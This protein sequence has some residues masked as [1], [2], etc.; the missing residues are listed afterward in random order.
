MELMP[1]KPLQGIPLSHKTM[2]VKILCVLCLAGLT[3]ACQT[4]PAVDD[5]HLSLG[6]KS[7]RFLFAGKITTLAFSQGGRVLIA[8]GCEI[9]DDGDDKQ[10]DCP[11]SLVQK[12]N[13]DGTN[14]EKTLRYLQRT[15]ALAVSPD[16]S[17]L[18]AGDSEGRLSLL[19][20]AAKTKLKALHQKREI[21]AL[22]FSPD[23]KWVAS[24][25]L[26]SSFPLGFLETATGGVVKVKIDFEPISALAFSPDGRDL[27][28]GTI[29]GGFFVWNF[30]SSATSSQISPNSNEQHAVTRTAYSSDGHL[31]AYGRRDGRVVILDRES[32]TVIREFKGSSA[33]KALAF[34]PDGQY[35][36]LGQDNGKVILIGSVQGGQVWSKRHLFPVA[37]IAYSPDGG[38]LAVAAQQH[39]YL[40]HVGE[41][42]EVLP[43]HQIGRAHV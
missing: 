43:L 35:L 29:K 1:T 36:A 6:E 22:A 31:L 7:E 12:W 17:H 15:T 5:Q 10:E 38:L 34:S 42:A 19:K 11:R 39:V 28:I 33:I 23:G 32:G 40:Y 8:G 16:G 3:G 26:D 2:L 14:S 41:S 20:G 21:T 25:S 30:L 13:L 18:A 27:A 9:D 4:V 37:D 24:G